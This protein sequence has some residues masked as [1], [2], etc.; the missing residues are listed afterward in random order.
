MAA[1]ARNKRKPKWNMRDFKV[2]FFFFWPDDSGGG[3]G[4]DGG[5][6][7]ILRS[8]MTKPVP[9]IYSD[10]HISVLLACPDIFICNTEVTIST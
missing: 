4:G 8:L 6:N 5:F 3:G 9:V 2:R 7:I 10:Q 1:H